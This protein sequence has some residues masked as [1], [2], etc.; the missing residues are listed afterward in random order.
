MPDNISW[1]HYKQADTMN[2][3]SLHPPLFGA[4]EK[5]K[6]ASLARDGV[7]MTI[8]NPSDA[9]ALAQLAAGGGG[10][11]LSMSMVGKKPLFAAA[12]LNTVAT[13]KGPTVPMTMQAW[14]PVTDSKVASPI[15]TLSAP[16]MKPKVS[17]IST[18]STP[19]AFSTVPAVKPTPFPSYLPVVGILILALVFLR[20]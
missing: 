13:A 20:K 12:G 14:A 15:S 2:N 9:R 4:A 8:R 7:N 16:V 18:I 11:T 5:K 17:S 10:S 1:Y 3:T 19:N 6:M